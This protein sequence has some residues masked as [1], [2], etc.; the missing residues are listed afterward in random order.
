MVFLF[1]CNYYKN[2]TQ[3]YKSVYLLTSTPVDKIYGP[4]GPTSIEE[5]AYKKCQNMWKSLPLT[6]KMVLLIHLYYEL[7]NII[8]LGDKYAP[9]ICVQNVLI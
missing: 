5:V 7:F 6:T 9:I 8:A 3:F 2:L 1:E 4:I